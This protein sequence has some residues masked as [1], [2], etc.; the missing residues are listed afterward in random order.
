MIKEGSFFWRKEEKRSL[1]KLEE[2][3]FVSRFVSKHTVTVH[4]A[5]RI[6]CAAFFFFFFWLPDR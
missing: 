5:S 1:H 2:L 3:K 6:L 4:T